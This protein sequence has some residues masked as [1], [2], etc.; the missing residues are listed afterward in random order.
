MNLQNFINRHRLNLIRVGL[1]FAL[2]FS[3]FLFVSIGCG[4]LLWGTKTTDTFVYFFNTTNMSTSITYLNHVYAPNFFI[5]D[6]TGVLTF[7][8]LFAVYCYFFTHI[9]SIGL[10]IASDTTNEHGKMSISFIYSLYIVIFLSVVAIFGALGGLGN[11]HPDKIPE[12]LFIF[13]VLFIS[14]ICV[15]L[16]KIAL[17]D[18]RNR[19]EEYTFLIHFLKSEKYREDIHLI[20]IFL[21]LASFEVII[22]GYLFGYNPISILCIDFLLLFLVW[23]LGIFDSFPTETSTIQLKTG[24]FYEGLVEISR[25]YVLENNENYV[26]FLQTDGRRIKINQDNIFFIRP[27]H[28]NEDNL[29]CQNQGQSDPQTPPLILSFLTSRNFLNLIGSAIALFLMVCLNFFVLEIPIIMNSQIPDVFIIIIFCAIIVIIPINILLGI[30]GTL[31]FL[32][33]NY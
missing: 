26:E 16:F 7:I 24:N 12:I 22:F 9:K 17:P 4:I 3:T 25:V 29:G 23:I 19:Y 15:F 27:I 28:K 1:K 11:L 18:E 8:G 2:F 21:F 10:K 13:F 30:L 5:K 6:F 33:K 32:S 20:S 31:A 14:L